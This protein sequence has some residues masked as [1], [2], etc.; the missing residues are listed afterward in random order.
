MDEVAITTVKLAASLVGALQDNIRQAFSSASTTLEKLTTQP[1][2]PAD[3]PTDLWQRAQFWFSQQDSSVLAALTL[4][5]IALVM[6]WSSRFGSWSGRFSPFGRS[7][8]SAQVKDSDYS[9]ITSDD[10][11][12]AEQR[13][14]SPTPSGPPRDTD[15]LVLKSKRISYPVHFPAY[16]IER[17]ELKI[18]SVREQAAKK[19]G[20]DARRIK[21][22]FRGK[23]MKEDANSCRTEGLRHNSEIMCVVGDNVPESMSSSD[24]EAEDASVDGGDVPKRKRNRNKNKKKKSKKSATPSGTPLNDTS[25]T[26]SPRPPPAPVTPMDK[27]N[28]VNSTLQTLLPQCVQF[29]ANPPPEQA[30]RE[31]E[32]KRLSET[33]LAQVLLKLDAVETEGE[34]EA[35]ARRKE[36]VREAQNVL[37]SLDDS[38]KS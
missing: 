10:L 6:S 7:G 15:V 19:T 4:T 11:K 36:L 29:L 26:Q 25:R 12:N 2:Q 35:R 33:V 13:E 32:H 37:N 34:P 23:N 21:L 17:G 14:A 24:S 1:I 16:T 9:Y 22:F 20:A 38:M 3:T 30:K 28:A 27:L 31:F 5:A 18:G 8:G